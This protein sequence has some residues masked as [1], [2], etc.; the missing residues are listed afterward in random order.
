VT[1]PEITDDRGKEM[2]SYRFATLKMFF[3]SWQRSWIEA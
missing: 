2:I 3:A 1:R